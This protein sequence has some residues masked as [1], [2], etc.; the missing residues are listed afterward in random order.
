MARTSCP[1]RILVPVH[2]VF[3][4]S[5]SVGGRERGQ[6]GSRSWSV[7]CPDIHSALIRQ[8]LGILPASSYPTDLTRLDTSLQGR[9]LAL[10][11]FSSQSYYYKPCQTQLRRSVTTREC[12]HVL[13]SQGPTSRDIQLQASHPSRNRRPHPPVQDSAPTITV[14]RHQASTRPP[15]QDSAHISTDLRQETSSWKRHRRQ[16]GLCG[17]FATGNPG[18]V[19]HMPRRP[20]HDQASSHLL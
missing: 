11:A 14:P 7:C 19:L 4:S 18:K 8:V 15:V 12:G 2:L 20:P 3:P 13:R 10:F 6:Q 17:R 16:D 1:R 9:V 5:V